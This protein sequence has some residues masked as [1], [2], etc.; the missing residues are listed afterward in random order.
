MKNKTML[1]AFVASLLGIGIGIGVTLMLILFWNKNGAASSLGIKAS[2][3]LSHTTPTLSLPTLSLKSTPTMKPIPSPSFT[4]TLTPSPFFTPTLTPSPF[5]TPTL[6]P[7]PSFP[8]PTSFAII[9]SSNYDLQ[10][11]FDQQ[12]YRP[13]KKI[14]LRVEA[15]TRNN[16]GSGEFRICARIFE[17]QITKDSKQREVTLTEGCHAVHLEA[18][19]DTKYSSGQVSFVYLPTGYSY[20]WTTVG[21]DTYK[22]RDI[23]VHAALYYGDGILVS[24]KASQRIPPVEVTSIGSKNGQ[25]YATVR[26]LGDNPDQTFNIKLEVSQIEFDPDEILGILL[27][28]SLGTLLCYDQQTIDST[29]TQVTLVKG[30]TQTLKLNFSPQPVLEPGNTI[31]SYEVGVYFEDLLIKTAK[32]G[33]P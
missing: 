5:S 4:P 29:V 14:S 11:H 25:A 3:P 13:G 30:E 7:S 22:I 21:E 27:G 32:V 24:T 20:V 33:Y 1:I 6:T 15:S 18:L 8:T 23:V 12:T 26:F 19:G 17:R 10:I 28:C 16:V 9:G 2:P 31:S